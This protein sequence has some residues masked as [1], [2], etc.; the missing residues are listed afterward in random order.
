MRRNRIHRPSPALVLSIVALVAALGGVAW[1]TVPTATGVIRGCYLKRGGQLRVLVGRFAKC[2]RTE[3]A[4]N[5]K[6]AGTVGPIGPAG[7]AGPT[8]PTGKSGANGTNGTNGMNGSNGTT[9]PG[10]AVHAFSASEGTPT[11]LMG[12]QTF[13]NLSLPAG[14]YLVTA[15]A[16][17]QNVDT[18][19]EGPEEVEC[20][21]IDSP[22]STQLSAV[23]AI[24]YIKGL[25]AAATLPIEGTWSLSRPA[26]LSLYCTQLTAG[27]MTVESAGVDAVSVADI[28]GS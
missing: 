9:G 11:E 13:L 23:D 14:K 3:T 22:F 4:L 18:E 27:S 25:Q 28:N 16:I 21:L 8:G 1:A 17:V 19:D 15:T 7:P 26:T 24:P 20:D 5:W 6:P 2:K 12:Q 10:G